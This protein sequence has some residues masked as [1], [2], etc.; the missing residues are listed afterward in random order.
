MASH[1]AG[2][3]EAIWREFRMVSGFMGRP[4]G[5]ATTCPL[6]CAGP[7][8]GSVPRGAASRRPGRRPL[9]LG[10]EDPDLRPVVAVLGDE[11]VMPGGVLVEVVRRLGVEDH[12]QRD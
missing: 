3:G 8:S 10:V 9:D 11:L 2:H 1:E 7:G 4:S 12:V 6:G 5:T